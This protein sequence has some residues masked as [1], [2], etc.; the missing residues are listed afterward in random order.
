[1]GPDEARPASSVSHYET[2]GKRFYGTMVGPWWYQWS[3]GERQV[4]AAVSG[5]PNPYVSLI[6]VR[7]GDGRIPVDAARDFGSIGGVELDAALRASEVPI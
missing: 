1:M 7:T 3:A 4:R 2:G 5:I 6:D